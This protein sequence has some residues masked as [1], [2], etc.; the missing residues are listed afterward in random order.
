[1]NEYILCFRNA[2]PN[3]YTP[4]EESCWY[5]QTFI[6]LAENEE[7]AKIKTK[8][9]ILSWEKEFNPNDYKKYYK[10]YHKMTFNKLFDKNNLL[11]KKLN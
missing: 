1:M 7:Q 5:G 8:E 10:Y 4:T 9:T 3:F 2:G 6:V 11:I